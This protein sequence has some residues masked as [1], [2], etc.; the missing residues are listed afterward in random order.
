MRRA[1][2]ARA[3]AR[4]RSTG[5]QPQGQHAV[6][7]NKC[8]ARQLG[9]A[10]AHSALKQRGVADAARMTPCTVPATISGTAAK[11]QCP[12]C[13]ASSCQSL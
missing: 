7:Q 2:G 9:S 5:R 11:L 13:V 4:V 1:A 6:P 8:R 12:N 3:H 10:R